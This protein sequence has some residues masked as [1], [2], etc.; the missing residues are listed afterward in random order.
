MRDFGVFGKRTGWTFIF[1][2]NSGRNV[3]VGDIIA[4]DLTDDQVVELAN[5]CL[6]YYRSNAKPNERTARFV[7][8]I[9]IEEFK[10]A[11]LE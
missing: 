9:G 7:Q 5:K 3:R 1:G 8:R 10:K 4:E 6:E 2:G 11:V